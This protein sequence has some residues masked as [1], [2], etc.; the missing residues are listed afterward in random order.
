MKLLGKKFEEMDSPDIV[1]EAFETYDTDGS[2]FVNKDTIRQALTSH[3]E[4]ISED[5]INTLLDDFDDQQPIDYKK[6]IEDYGF[7]LSTRATTN[8]SDPS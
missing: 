2:G 7:D 6:L 4:D 3:I 8:M 1:K 5:E